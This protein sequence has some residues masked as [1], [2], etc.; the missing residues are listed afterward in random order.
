MRGNLNCWQSTS[1]VLEVTPYWWVK[2]LDCFFPTLYASSRNTQGAQCDRS[3]VTPYWWVK[4]LDCFVPRNDRSE[5][6][7]YWW[8][9][10]LDCFVPRNDRSEVI[11]SWWSRF[12][13]ASFLLFVQTVAIPSTLLR[14]HMGHNVTD[15]KSYRLGG[16]RF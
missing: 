8:V 7:P 6:T 11:P 12:K 1:L 16:S 15:R 10:I 3:E 14:G 5:V 9:E 2:I 4:I 13:I